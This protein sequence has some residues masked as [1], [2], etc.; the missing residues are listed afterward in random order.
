MLLMGDEYGH[1]RHGNNNPYVQDNEINWFLWDQIDEKRIDFIS[2]LSAFRKE[3]PSLHQTRFL[4]DA[5]VKWFTDWGP[6]SKLVVYQLKGPPSLCVAFNA[7][8]HP[9]SLTL[10]QTKGSWHTVVNTADDW[11]I[12]KRGSPISCLEL[13]PFSAFLAIEKTG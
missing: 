13:L 1:T 4:V 8:S 11:L 6:A 2:S 5:D 12:Q 10:P 7:N 3:H 9:I